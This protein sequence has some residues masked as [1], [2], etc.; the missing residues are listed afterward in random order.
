MNQTSTGTILKNGTASSA[1]R[2]FRIENHDAALPIWKNVAGKERILV[3]VDAHHDM[4]WV[5]NDKNITIA[6]FIS[7]AIRDGI[8]SEIY[9]VVPDRSWETAENRGHILR[10]L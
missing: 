6:N 5:E 2:I 7:P 10:H 4:W 9:W 8:L 3:H 1:P